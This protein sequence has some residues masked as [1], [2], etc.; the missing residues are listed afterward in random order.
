[1][2][3]YFE[4]AKAYVAEH[5]KQFTVGTS[6]VVAIIIVFVGL[7]LYSYNTAQPKIVFEPANACDLF[8][9]DEAKTLLGDQ[10]IKTI[11]NTPVQQK[12]LTV[13]N[14][15]YSDGLADTANARVAAI[16]IRSAINDAG[17]Q[18]NKTQFEAGKPT[19]IQEVSGIGDTAYFNA[20][21]GQLN[22]LKDTTWVIVSYGAGADPTANTLEDDT[23]LAK[24]V[25]N[26]Q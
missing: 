18:E 19:G 25:L 9:L 12:N 26:Q 22:I 15:A 11:T 5:K 4:Q 20:G 14:C 8:T 3:N 1:M 24:L 2:K 21:L 23:Q 16:N 6:V 17:I 7:S 10:T 13:S